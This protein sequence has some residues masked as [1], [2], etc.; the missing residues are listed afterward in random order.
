MLLPSH[1]ITASV[2]ILIAIALLFIER[3]EDFA[4]AVRI[5]STLWRGGN[6]YCFNRQNT[7]LATFYQLYGGV[8][9][10]KSIWMK[11]TTQYL[12]SDDLYE[13]SLQALFVE[14][15]IHKYE[16]TM[17]LSIH[18]Y[19]WTTPWTKLILIGCIHTYKCITY[20]RA[21]ITTYS[22]TYIIISLLLKCSY[23]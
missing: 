8:L 7:K 18:K 22:V 20:I 2:N 9:V 19:E 3:G 1:F 6:F 15:S 16:W 21:D 23:N 11:I 17:E 10:S 14:L 5:I 4:F 13:R 12:L